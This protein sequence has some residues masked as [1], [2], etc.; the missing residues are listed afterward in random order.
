MLKNILPLSIIAIYLAVPAFAE[1][2]PDIS[3]TD[4]GVGMCVEPVLGTY[5]GPANL[6]A[7]WEGNPIDIRWYNNNSLIIPTNTASNGCIYGTAHGAATGDLIEPTAPTRTGYTFAG[8][9]IRPQTT[10]SNS[11][12]GMSSTGLERWAK[13]HVVNTTTPYCYHAAPG[14]SSA[15]VVACNSDPHL[16]EL[17]LDEWQMRYDNNGKT[18]YGMAYCSGKA[19][20]AH[21]SWP[22]ANRSDWEETNFSNLENASG[23]KKYCW[24]KAT[25]YKAN[26]SAVLQGPDS[27]L[28]WVF[29]NDYGSAANCA[30]YCACNCAYFA[31]NL[32]AFRAALF[33]GSGN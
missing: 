25:G 15:T 19:G 9:T 4:D 11:A 30:P 18:L 16:T 17:S 7:D 23:V 12:L 1:D 3:S 32:S 20:D 24:C 27:S 2:T 14:E 28:S 31:Q 5:T 10:F 29:S 22:V 13:G 8:W 26:S 6:Q 21:S 33:L